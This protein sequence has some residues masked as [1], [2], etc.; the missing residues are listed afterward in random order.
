MRLIG[1]ACALAFIWRSAL[2]AQSPTEQGHTREQPASVAE[3]AQITARGRAVAAYDELAWHATDAVQAMH[4]AESEGGVYLG[5]QTSR[6]LVMGF[7]HLNVARTKFLLA[8]ESV[9]GSPVRNPSVVHHA[10]ALEE[11]GDWLYEALSVATVKP[12]IKGEGSIYNLAVLPADAGRWFVYAYPAQTE[13]GVYPT[14]SDVRYLVSANG[15]KVVETHRMHYS[16]LQWSLP[17]DKS[18]S[19][20]FR[21]EVLDD[22]PE[23]TDVAI[24]LMMGGYPS[25][26]AT[27]K[28]VYLIDK[29]GE[30]KYVT[31][32]SVF[33][34]KAK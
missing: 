3:L 34:Q 24:C 31:T 15:L 14:G 10:P 22:A 16:L 23:D 25:Y 19:T 26:V 1:L 12:L 8:Y 5:L 32:T 29:S 27:P 4:P 2:S 9:P 30:I 28:F 11:G 13:N 33:M 20:F 18:E 17:K 21:T 6:G 7:G